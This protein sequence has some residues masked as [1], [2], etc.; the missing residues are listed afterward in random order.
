MGRHPIDPRAVRDG[1][2]VTSY[3]FDRKPGEATIDYVERLL[4]EPLFRGATAAE[5]ALQ[6]GCPVSLVHTVRRDREAGQVRAATS[7]AFLAECRAA[8]RDI[9]WT[10]SDGGL[11]EF[12]R[13]A[14][15]EAKLAACREGRCR[16][17]ICHAPSRPETA[18]EASTATNPTPVDRTGG[19]GHPRGSNSYPGAQP[20]Q[21]SRGALGT[22]NPGGA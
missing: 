10:A 5:I 21:Q 15:V 11:V 16:H 17:K 22:R 12:L 9:G 20:G 3:A 7:E 19:S 4:V 6:A 8:A 18:A 14:L 13:A 1:L 2:G